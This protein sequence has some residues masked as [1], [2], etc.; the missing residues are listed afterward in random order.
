MTRADGC[1]PTPSHNLVLQRVVVIGRVLLKSAFLEC[2]PHLGGFTS[3]LHALPKPLLEPAN[4]KHPFS[5][6]VNFKRVKHNLQRWMLFSVVIAHRWR[7][8]W[9]LA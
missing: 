9:L 6:K 2:S 5:R 3:G 1:H 7:W 4:V 8:A